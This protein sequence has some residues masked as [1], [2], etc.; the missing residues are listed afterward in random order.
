MKSSI[1]VN[2]FDRKQIKLVWTSITVRDIYD[3]AYI[4]IALEDFILGLGK[5]NGYVG[6]SMEVFLDNPN[7]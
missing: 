7:F 5:F 6:R 3:P 4:V 2:L 1:T